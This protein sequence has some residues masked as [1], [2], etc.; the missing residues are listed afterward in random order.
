MKSVNLYKHPKKE[1]RVRFKKFHFYIFK[2]FCF[3]ILLIYFF[4]VL[5]ACQISRVPL[6][7][8]FRPDL[9]G[10]SR[11]INFSSSADVTGENTSKNGNSRE[12]YLFDYTKIK[13]EQTES[14]DIKIKNC[15]L[16]LDLY[17]DLLIFGEILNASDISKTNIQVTFNF[18][19]ANGNEIESKI[20]PVYVDYLR[21]NALLPFCFVYDDR[22]KYISISMIKVGVNYDNY[23]ESFIGN[24]VVTVESFYYKENMLVFKGNVENIG[25]NKVEDLKLFLTLYDLRDRVVSVKQC[26]L[27]K[28]RLDELENQKFEARILLDEYL[29]DFTHYHFEIFFRDSLKV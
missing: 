7:N 15:N 25:Q 8:S 23:K 14:I 26:F 2:V 13:I 29:K 3:S 9:A 18:Y 21:A 11:S 12:L 6:E 10:S 1:H 22:N 20:M 28:D 17:G 5:S 27:F 4:S 24:P 16:Y 19:D